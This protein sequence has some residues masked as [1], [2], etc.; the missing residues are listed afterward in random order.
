M[1]TE[2]LLS[3]LLSPSFASSLPSS[4][5]ARFKTLAKEASKR[6]PAEARIKVLVAEFAA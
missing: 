5:V 1:K 3:Q 4:T 2:A 6:L